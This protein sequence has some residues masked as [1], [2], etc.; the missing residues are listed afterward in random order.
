MADPPWDIHMSVRPSISWNESF[1][2]FFFLI[3]VTLRNDDG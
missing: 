3:T 2:K 1:V